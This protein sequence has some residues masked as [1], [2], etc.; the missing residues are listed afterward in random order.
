M[1][2][3]LFWFLLFLTKNINIPIIE[4]VTA[5][6]IAKYKVLS[7]W[8]VGLGRSVGVAS[9]VGVG[10]GDGVAGIGEL[11]GVGDFEGTGEEVGI[12]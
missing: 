5:I 4:I 6:S 10:V 9:G 2:F 12:V 7:S 1:I 8:I 3:F 11:V